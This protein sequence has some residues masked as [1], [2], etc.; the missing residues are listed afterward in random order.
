M[1]VSYL[2]V[3][4]GRQSVGILT[5]SRYFT[6]KRAKAARLQGYRGIEA[7]TGQFFL[8]RIGKDT[9]CL[10]RDVVGAL[11]R[12]GVVSKSPTAKRDLLLVQDAFNEWQQ[13]SGR[14]LCAIP[15]VLSCSIEG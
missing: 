5:G 12:Q 1:F 3:L 2:C 6:K 7:R 11:V 14:P 9:F 8:R 4:D 15:R 10:T 13:Q